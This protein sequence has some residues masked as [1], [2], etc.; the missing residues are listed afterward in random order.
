VYKLTSSAFIWDDYCWKASVRLRVWDG[1]Q[2]RQGAYGS[3]DSDDPSEGSVYIV[4][5]PEGADKAPLRQRDLVLIHWATD[6]AAEMQRGM[7]DKLLAQYAEIQQKYKE[8][9][10]AED[11]PT[12]RSVQEFRSLIGLHTLNVHPIHH[13]GVP[14]VGFEFGCSWDAEHGLGILMHGTRVV[15]IGGADTAILQWIA[16]KDA[17]KEL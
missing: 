16:E 6:H 12:V 9:V 2:S 8:F 5:S 13:K 11:L 14:Y 4:F 3:R 1:F 15:E 17:K 10:E 7:L